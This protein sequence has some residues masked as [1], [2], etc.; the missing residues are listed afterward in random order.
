[1]AERLKTSRSKFSGA[2][3]A[4]ALQSTMNRHQRLLRGEIIDVND[5]KERMSACILILEDLVLERIKEL[6][7][8]LRV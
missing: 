7:N 6:E 2:E 3:L 1:M 5:T 8:A 4:D